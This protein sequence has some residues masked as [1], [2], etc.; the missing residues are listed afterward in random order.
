MVNQDE[1]NRKLLETIL[2]A[3]KNTPECISLTPKEGT[4]SDL[5]D[6][7][8]PEIKGAEPIDVDVY[9]RFILSH[10]SYRIKEKTSL[11]G[12]FGKKLSESIRDHLTGMG[13]TGAE[14][15]IKDIANNLP[16]YFEFHFDP[17]ALRGDDRK[18]YDDIVT[19]LYSKNV[20]ELIKNRSLKLRKDVLEDPDSHMTLRF[21]AGLLYERCKDKLNGILHAYVI[22]STDS[23]RHD[24]QKNGEGILVLEQD[25][26]PNE[27]DWHS[28]FQRPDNGDPGWLK[29]VWHTHPFS[30][31]GELY[32]RAKVNRKRLEKGKIGPWSETFEVGGT[33]FDL[34]DPEKLR[35]L[36]IEQKIYLG[37]EHKKRGLKDWLVYGVLI[38]SFIPEVTG[39]GLWLHDKYIKKRPDTPPVWQYIIPGASQKPPKKVDVPVPTPLIYT[40]SGCKDNCGPY[41]PPAP[42]EYTQ[43]GCEQNCNQYFTCPPAP[44]CKPEIRTVEK[45][46]IVEKDKVCPP[47]EPCECR[48]RIEPVQKSCP[49]EGRREAP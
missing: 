22:R 34:E 2:D 15:L 5:L 13:W 46:V 25:N 33:A 32:R 40:E 24:G 45:P 3:I 9:K 30:T 19:K 18:T 28:D 43:Q 1:L 23:F 20:L 16:K 11:D 41:F 4:L 29:R 17:S 26:K 14:S 12:L 47:K 49:G 48:D 8:E 6:I 7:P 38:A 21:D 36:P 39:F 44:E 27:P 37:K 31:F 10:M 42:A 35:D